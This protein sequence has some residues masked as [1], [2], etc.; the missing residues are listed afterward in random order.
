[1]IKIDFDVGK[2]L[3][4]NLLGLGAIFRN[5]KGRISTYIN[6]AIKWQRSSDTYFLEAATVLNALI[7]ATKLGFS[8]VHLECDSLRVIS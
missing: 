5:Y 7:L 6:M 1:M 2:I 8:N 3:N 4:G